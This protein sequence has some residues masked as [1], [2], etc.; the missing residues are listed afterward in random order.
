MD[1]RFK[2]KEVEECKK[3][4]EGDDWHYWRKRI[5]FDERLDRYERDSREDAFWR[6]VGCDCF[7]DT[8]R[9]ARCVL[10]AAWSGTQDFAERDQLP[11]ECLC[12]EVAGSRADH[13][14]ECRWF[15]AGRLEAGRVSCGRSVLRPDERAEVDVLRRWNR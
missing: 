4:G 1:G 15:A 14:G 10:G 6:P 8:R 3:P 11:G 5:V 12:D 7:G 13:F 9:E 2:N